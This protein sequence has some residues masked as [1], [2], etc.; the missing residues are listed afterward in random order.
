MRIGIVCYPTIGGSGV[1]ATEL[2]MALAKKGHVVHFIAYQQPYRLTSVSKNIHFHEVRIPEYPLFNDPQYL[3]ALSSK[4]VEVVEYE[5]L[6]LIHVHYAIPH[7][8]AAFLAQ[9]ILKQKN[10]DIPVLTTLHGTDISL[11]G[12]DPSYLPVVE[13]SINKSDIVTA[14]SNALKEDT[15]D[16]FNI[17]KEINVIHNFI[18]TE[19]FKPVNSPKLRAEF[20][21]PDELIITH[22]SNFRPVKRIQDILNMFNELQKSVKTKL[23]LIGDGP[24][25]YKLEQQCR[26]LGLCDK[27]TFLGKISA[28]EKILS[29]SDIFVLPSETESFGLSALEALACGVP[30]ISS[31]AGGL[32]EV[33]KDGFSGFT[34]DVGDY[35]QMAIKGLEIVNNLEKFKANAVI[36]ANNFTLDEIIPK[37]ES[38]YKQLAPQTTTELA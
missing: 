21:E 7:A 17:K 3:L 1:V 28:V 14:V 16:H 32:P 22:T 5:K 27:I 25:R 19:Q 20:A 24:E 23:L 30:V 38:L 6:D 10:I 26:T 36:Q 34:C 33:N 8:T 4:L 29:I 13:Y 2:G 18:N 12:K 37:Y 9:D 15:I 31:N 35:K 11:V